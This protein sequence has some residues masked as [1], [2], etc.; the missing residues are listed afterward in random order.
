MERV[1]I[2][3]GKGGHHIPDDVVMRRCHKGLNNLFRLFM[4]ICDTW[5]LADNSIESLNIVA[6]KTEF[7]N[8]IDNSNIWGEINKQVS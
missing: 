7:G 2:R 8:A 6:Y 1:A 5:T 3:V 4:P